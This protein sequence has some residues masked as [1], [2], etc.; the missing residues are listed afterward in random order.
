M[1]SKI[2][3]VGESCMDIFIY[4]DTP[5]LSPEG[6]A[7]V[8]IPTQEKYNGGMASNVESNLISLGCEVDLITNTSSITK[9]RYVHESSNTLL[10]RV[11][12]GDVV[13][14]VEDSKLKSVDYWEYNMVIIS[15]YN[16]GFLTE[17][18]IA[19]ISYKHPNTICDTKKKLGEWCRDIRFIKLNRSEF[20]NNK[21]F[22][23]QNDWILEK[24]IITLDKDG[25]KHNGKIYPTEQV[26]ILDIS[27]AGDTFV[28]SF[29]K[30][31]IETSDVEQSIT[32]ANECSSKVVQKRGVTTI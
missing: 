31:Y 23:K 2:L 12:E 10:L 19:Y 14:Q 24:L 17:E 6:P 8:F 15:D 21:D 28:A 16:K 30:K 11:D 5:R 9:T 7:P 26:E 25:C 1:M 18:D 22:I 29:S 13:K 32:F 20:E 4:G 3:V 27:G